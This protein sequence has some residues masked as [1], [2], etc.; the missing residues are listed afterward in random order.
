M[1]AAELRE[2]L[3]KVPDNCVVMSNSG[4]ECDPTD[5]DGVWYC[6]EVNEVHLTRGGETE[7]KPAWGY[8]GQFV[9]IYCKEEGGIA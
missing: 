1:T 2:H 8:S 9:K 6:P 5:I 7:Y 3:Q 4:W